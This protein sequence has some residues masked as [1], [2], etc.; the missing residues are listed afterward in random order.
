MIQDG[1][2]CQ[3]KCPA[4]H[5]SGIEGALK[6][7]IRQRIAAAGI[8]VFDMEPPIPADYCLLNAKNVTLTPH[9]AFLSKESMI[10]RAK[11]EFDNVV[12]YIKG[13]KKNICTF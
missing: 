10:R 4:E 2:Q 12:S 1:N 7:K 11:I 13:E 6:I 8:D 9:V 3:D 5:K